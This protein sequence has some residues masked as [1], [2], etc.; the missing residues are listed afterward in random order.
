[1]HSK[2]YKA[3]GSQSERGDRKILGS[4]LL[5]A[6]CP[7]LAAR[8]A[9]AAWERGKSLELT[10]GPGAGA[11]R[12]TGLRRQVEL[13]RSRLRGLCLCCLCDGPRW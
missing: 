7:S 5:S 12:G 4:C 1:M 9:R 6:L 8:E 10:T 2:V 13:E 11:E 3:P